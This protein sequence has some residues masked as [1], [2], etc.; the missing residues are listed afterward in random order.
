[1]NCPQT[2]FIRIS[3]FLLVPFLTFFRRLGF[4]VRWLAALGLVAGWS[5]PAF[6]QG[7]GGNI[8]YSGAYTIHTFTT[9]G[10]FTVNAPIAADIVV[11]AGGGGGGHQHAGG[12]GAG[13]VVAASIPSITNGSY[14]I[15]VGGFGNGCSWYPYTGSNGGNSS[16]LGVTANGGGAGTGMSQYGNDGG[17]GGG[18][19]N[20]SGGV[21]GGNGIAGMGNNGSRGGS[22]S[23]LNGGGGG[24]AGGAGWGLAG[25]APTTNWAG[26]FA[27]G[28]GGGYGGGA[29][30]GAGA[31]NGGWGASYGAHATIANTGSGGGGGGNMD[32]YGGNGSAGIVVIKYLT[33]VAPADSGYFVSQSIPN[34]VNPGQV[35]TF[36]QTW[37]NNGTATW[38]AA[39]NYNVGSVNPYDNTTFGTGR[40]GTTGTVAPGA[41]VTITCTATA[42]ALPGL[43]NIQTG[44]VHDG[45]TWFGG[46]SAFANITVVNRPPTNTTSIVNRSGTILATNPTAVVNVAYGDSFYI[47]V[48]GTDPDGQLKNLY[49]RMDFVSGTGNQWDYPIYSV[50]G[51]SASHDF[52]P[53]NTAD[54]RALGLLNIWTHVEDSW[55]GPYQWQGDGWWG[56]DQPDVNIVKATPNLNFNDQAFG[57]TT[58]MGAANLP[59]TATSPFPYYANVALPTGNITYTVIAATGGAIPSSGLVAVGTIFYPGTYTVRAYYPGDGW[60]NTVTLD[61][62][63]TIT[64]HVPTG[65][66]TIDGIQT[67]KTIEFGQIIALSSTMTDPDGRLLNHSFFWDQGTGKT[68]T[69]PWI[70]WD[71]PADATGWSSM[72]NPGYVVVGGTSTRTANFQAW[73]AGA[74]QFKAIGDDGISP[75]LLGT[76]TLSV[77]NGTPVINT[78]TGG[79]KTPQSGTN[80]TVSAATD[81]NA[82]FKNQ[83]SGTVTPPT[84][85]IS[86]SIA[87]GS[88]SGVINSS[89][90]QGTLLTAGLTYKIRATIAAQP[91]Y[92]NTAY[93]D[94]NWNIAKASQ[95]ISWSAAPNATYVGGTV[96]FTATGAS[97]GS[98]VWSVSPT[99]PTGISGNGAS[100]SITFPAGGNFTVSVYGAGNTNANQSATINSTIAVDV[101][102]TVSGSFSRTSISFGESSTFTFSA[103]QGS[104]ALTGL[105]ALYWTGASWATVPGV[106][107]NLTNWPT[108]YP[109]DSTKFIYSSS[110][111]VNETASGTSATKS[112]IVTPQNIGTFNGFG[113]WAWDASGTSSSS[114]LSGGITVTQSDPKG[115]FAAATKSPPAGSNYTVVAGDLNATF[116]NKFP[117][118]LVARPAGTITYTISSLSVTGTPGDPVTAGTPL[119]AG[120]VYRIRATIAPAG[121]YLGSFVDSLDWTITL[122]DVT[123]PTVPTGVATSSIANTTFTLTWT[124]STDAVGVTSYRVYQDGSLQPIG[125]TAGTSYVVPALLPGSSYSMTVS[126]SDAVPNWSAQSA[127]LIVVTTADPNADADGD[128]VPDVIEKQ[129]GTNPSA[130]TGTAS[131]GS[132]QLKINTPTQ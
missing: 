113:V 5:T 101:L 42:P 34:A 99:G 41:T 15:T 7:A 58:T 94:V 89:V 47:R 11:V 98:Y 109:N 82:T 130:A 26:T 56:S 123:P 102:P 125:T 112:F 110:T 96:V 118:T 51:V 126:A 13:G 32:A 55:A 119:T 77:A 49:S 27:G 100:Q 83:Y 122:G 128:G 14:T 39:G 65:S 73:R 129:F 116:A 20:P 72:A 3:T 64:N 30:G 36:T 4:S 8:T 62:T 114:I 132:V 44:L 23:T 127:A 105:S 92:Y 46:T 43:Y 18:D 74:F 40:Y 80:F 84:G 53:Y 71:Y 9:S 50:S 107:Y 33:Q 31:G 35:F 85:A 70:V 12:G 97:S 131:A 16:A 17:S 2:T 88:P 108:T 124:P 67:G 66:F 48:A 103:T 106:T 63:F 19:G 104:T 1:M 45:V 38:S 54:G 121:N 87:P 111:F 37:T 10:M 78:F 115:T 22:V 95:T 117:G 21:Q 52:G 6:S 59:T 120:K 61:R 28:G 91:S 79:A 24:G 90:G 57:S 81:L 68:W 29:G 25:G 93:S 69:N 60:Y 76:Y 75:V 86:Y